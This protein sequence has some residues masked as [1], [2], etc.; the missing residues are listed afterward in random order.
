MKIHFIH[1]PL[2]HFYF[3]QKGKWKMIANVCFEN[4]SKEYSARTIN[5]DKTPNYF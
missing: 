3:N 1:T 4:Y 5:N 2:P